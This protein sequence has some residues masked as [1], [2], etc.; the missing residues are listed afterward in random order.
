MYLIAKLSKFLGVLAILILDLTTLR[1]SFN[2]KECNFLGYSSNW[3]SYITSVEEFVS[4]DVL[5]N[6]HKFPYS[7]LFPK[8][9]MQSTSASSTQQSPSIPLSVLPQ[10]PSLVFIQH[11]QYLK[12][13]HHF[14]LSTCDNSSSYSEQCLIISTQDLQHHLLF[15]LLS[16]NLDSSFSPTSFVHPDNNHPMQT[17]CK[18]GIVK[19]CLHPTLF[20]TE[21]QALLRNNTWSLVSLP[22]HMHAIGCKSVFCTEQNPDEEEVYMQQPPS[23]QTAGKNLVCRLFKAIYGL[24]QPLKPGLKGLLQH[25]LEYVNNIS[26][27][28]RAVGMDDLFGMFSEIIQRSCYSICATWLEK[29]FFLLK[30]NADKSVTCNFFLKTSTRG[31]NRAK[32]HQTRIRDVGACGKILE[33]IKLQLKVA[34]EQKK[35]ENEIYLEEFQEDRDE[36]DKELKCTKDLLKGHGEELMKYECSIMLHGWMDWKN[37]T[38]INILEFASMILEKVRGDSTIVQSITRSGKKDLYSELLWYLTFGSL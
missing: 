30:G 26:S 19:P 37:R 1:L 8:S 38:L 32:K 15:T 29:D 2:S 4:M 16:L 13:C 35:G 11:S 10:S 27:I 23:F 25:I 28:S 5:F 21:Y 6:E 34:Y 31:L 22:S 7:Y 36:E 17:R 9:F 14:K 12:S 20:L 33:D 18:Y 3:K 24:K